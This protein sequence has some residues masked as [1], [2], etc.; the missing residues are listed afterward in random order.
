LPTTIGNDIYFSPGSFDDEDY[1]WMKSY[2]QLDGMVMKLVPIKTR[3]EKDAGP[4]DMGQVDSDKMYDIV[5]KWDWGNGESSKIY[6]D[7]ETR[8]NSVNFRTNMS[9]L[10]NQLIIEG[11]KDKAKKIVELAVTKMP[12]EKFGYYSL[13]EPFAKNYYQL[14]E[15]AKAH[16]L[17][18]K[19]MTKYKENLDYYSKKT[20]FDQSLISMEIITDIERYRSLLLVMK[21]NG[22]V[23]FYNK[24][25]KVFNTYIEIY[26]DFERD[27]E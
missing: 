3:V 10:V 8:R 18:E 15:T 7:P 12:L 21:D 9:R 1:I 26:K 13:I 5:M 27:K 14:G 2:L 17:L 23:A 24:N 25:K 19:L 6:H 22:D 20:A 11:K 16:D 4:M